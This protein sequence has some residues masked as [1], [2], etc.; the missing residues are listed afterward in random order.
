MHREQFIKRIN[1]FNIQKKY[2]E[3]YQLV[4]AEM[5]DKV[6][7]RN[8]YEFLMK[9]C[10]ELIDL[11]YKYKSDDISAEKEYD[12]LFS[13]LLEEVYNH[14]LKIFGYE[15]ILKNEEGLNLMKALIG[16]FNLSYKYEEQVQLSKKIVDSDLVTDIEKK[17]YALSTLLSPDSFI[18]LTKEEWEQYI[19]IND[20]KPYG[21]QLHEFIRKLSK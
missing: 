6:Y 13:D 11:F 14:L 9:I 18:F 21:K 1:D 15:Q 4:C 20:T 2:E 12:L 5:T 16:V 8:D 17:E 3:F 19:N 7:N 10:D